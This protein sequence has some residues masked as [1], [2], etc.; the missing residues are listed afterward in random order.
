MI[1][2]GDVSSAGA[3]REAQ[4]VH[5]CALLPHADGRATWL[6]LHIVSAEAREIATRAGLQY[7]EDRCLIIEQRRLRIDAPAR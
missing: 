5:Q 6:Q 1:R 4:R 3:E 7:V 2:G